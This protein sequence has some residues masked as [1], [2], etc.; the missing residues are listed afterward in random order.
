ME[1]GGSVRRAQVLVIP[2]AREV[3]IALVSIIA[4]GHLHSYII[5]HLLAGLQGNSKCGLTADSSLAVTDVDGERLALRINQL[6][7][8][9]S[10]RM[11]YA[12]IA[13]FFQADV[14]GHIGSLSH[15][16]WHNEE[17]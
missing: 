11:L 2:E 9:C 5:V 13:W 15:R 8:L 6:V 1:R 17:K 3:E 12:G 10:E 7:A 16:H 14:I 4:R